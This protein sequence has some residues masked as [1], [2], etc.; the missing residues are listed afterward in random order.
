MEGFGTEPPQGPGPHDPG[1]AAREAADRIAEQVRDITWHFSASG[2][3]DFRTIEYRLRVIFPQE[4]PLLLESAG[5]RIEA[6]FGEFT[7]EEFGSSSPRQVSVC[8]P[9]RY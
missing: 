8:V 1:R 9:I 4:L 7:R 6:R 5:F 2:A 3:T